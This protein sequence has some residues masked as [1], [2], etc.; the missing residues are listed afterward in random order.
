MS[1]KVTV[2]V[3]S[4]QEIGARFVNAWHRVERGQRVREKH[5]TF[6]DLPASDADE[7]SQSSASRQS[8]VP[9]RRDK[10]LL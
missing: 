5:L 8:P 2:H 9:G 4:M 1:K 7:C 10:A 3:G 6:A